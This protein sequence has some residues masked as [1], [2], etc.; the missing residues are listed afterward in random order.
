MLLS[1]L[2]CDNILGTIN[3]I[4]R[5][6]FGAGAIG[7]REHL[8]NMPEALGSILSPAWSWKGRCVVSR[9]HKK[10]RASVC[11][12]AL[13]PWSCGGGTLH[14]RNTWLWPQKQGERLEGEAFQVSVALALSACLLSP[15]KPWLLRH[16]LPLRSIK[17][18]TKPMRHGLWGWVRHFRSKL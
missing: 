11:G 18:G 3:F 12:S 14:G 15:S 6:R 1:F 5:N 9:F 17:L 2:F 7:Q 16:P 10:L 13:L 8:H 4:T